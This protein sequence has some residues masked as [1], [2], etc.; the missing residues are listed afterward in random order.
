MST[1]VPYLDQLVTL[2]EALADPLQTSSLYTSEV[3]DVIIGELLG[4]GLSYVEWRSRLGRTHVWNEA[5]KLRI[6]KM[7]YLM[8]KPEIGRM[9]SEPNTNPGL[10]SKSNSCSQIMKRLKGK[11]SETERLERLATRTLFGCNAK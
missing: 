11:T 8:F 2:K 7:E 4:Q 9:L 1:H 5:L 3:S 6:I 10:K